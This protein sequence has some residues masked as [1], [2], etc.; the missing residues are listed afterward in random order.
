MRREPAIPVSADGGPSCAPGASRVGARVV[1]TAPRSR[2]AVVAGAFF[3][4]LLALLACAPGVVQPPAAWS[5]PEK[6]LFRLMGAGRR[7]TYEGVQSIE[8][9]FRG[10]H[11][12]G[13][14]R[15]KQM[16][17][18]TRTEIL[19][20]DRMKGTV[21]L[22]R[23]GSQLVRRPGAATWQPRHEPSPM[24]NP[25][26]ILHNYSVQ[27]AGSGTIAG[28][29]AGIL[30]IRMR[31]VG[32]LMR[33]L[34]VDQRTGVVLRTEVYNWSG[35]LVSETEFSEIDYSPA[36]DAQ[37]FKAPP[38]SDIRPRAQG[39]PPEGADAPKPSFLPPGYEIV[40]TPRWV[41]SRVGKAMH[42][43]YSDGLIP[44]SVFVR[45]L[46][47]GEPTPGARKPFPAM[48]Q[49]FSSVIHYV[50]GDYRV[51]II[52]DRDPDELR[53]IAESVE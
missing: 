27:L 40:G 12:K 48:D 35:Q 44:I 51:T 32:K 3:R 49:P 21:I 52:G 46:N 43:R 53:K 1:R 25:R 30:E 7:A 41:T 38:P 26:K 15:V 24:Q 8:M 29:E 18:C 22:E 23:D 36:L 28:R 10:R 16:Q 2:R 50:K 37:E 39:A 14:A 47:P 34:W 33:K 11:S 42:L 5:S 6:H 4:L 13:T 19:G 9:R 45:R 20:P 31:P 17:R